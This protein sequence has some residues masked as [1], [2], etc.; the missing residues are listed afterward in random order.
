VGGG[1]VID[2]PF[3]PAFRLAMRPSA[4]I[5]AL[6][7]LVDADPTDL[8]ML[9]EIRAMTDPLARVALTGLSAI[10]PA[11]RYV[12]AGAGAVMLPFL[13]SRPSRF[14][15]GRFGV[16]YGADQNVTALAEVTHHQTI[17][18]RA[19]GAPSG[20]SILFA[21]WS[22]DFDAPIED[23]RGAD[24]AV[25]DPASYAVAQKLGN[26]FHD[27]GRNGVLFRSV[28]RLEGECFGIFRPSVVRGMTKHDDWRL[29]WDGRTISETLRV[30]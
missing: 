3:M 17:R 27:D 20:T 4:D 6:S 14:S 8:E 2:P 12:G 13:I 21:L 18:L 11:D 16:L 30:A 5:A 19:A 24:T 25:Y 1:L 22:F 26:R 9:L 23:V 10:G 28:R 15:S 7:A 29:I